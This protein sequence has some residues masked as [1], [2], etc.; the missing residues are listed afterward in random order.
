[1][2]IIDVVYRSLG[3]LPETGSAHTLEINLRSRARSLCHA[4]ATL[5]ITSRGYR[6]GRGQR[7]E[8]RGRGITQIKN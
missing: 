6:G 5:G 8:G 1:M 4:R 2:Q 7:A 3:A